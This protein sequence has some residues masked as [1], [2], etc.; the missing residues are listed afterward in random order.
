LV[1]AY[2]GT[3]PGLPTATFGAIERQAWKDK[4]NPAISSF[5]KKVFSMLKRRKLFSW[6]D[7]IF[8]SSD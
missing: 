3:I 1:S 6:T 2:A 8:D 5:V 7:F 4:M